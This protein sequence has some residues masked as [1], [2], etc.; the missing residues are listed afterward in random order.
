MDFVGE[1]I[2][3]K[4]IAKKYSLDI[5]ASELKISKHILKKLENDDIDTSV[6]FVFYLGHLRSY[7]NFL[8][9]N[10]NEIVKQFKLQNSFE[11]VEKINESVEKINQ[12]QKP[13]VQNYFFKPHKFL[14]IVSILIIFLSFYFLF[15]DNEKSAPEYALIPDIPE[16]LEPIIEKTLIDL[17]NRD[18]PT[19]YEK[20][21]AQVLLDNISSS[22]AIASSKNSDEILSNQVVTLKFLNPTWVQLRDLNNEII[23]SQLMSKNEEYTYDLNLNY[24]LTAGN[25]GNILVLIDNNIRGKI[26]N[27]GEVV[28]SIVIDNNFNN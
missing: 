13:I 26:G 28:D 16:N 25:A 2:R 8:K 23:V 21:S 20:T 17:E 18:L 6:N 3:K 15:V 4:R 24:V 14:S 10:T 12:I 1:Y 19:N 11:S 5:V 22:S 7:A 9:L 27:F